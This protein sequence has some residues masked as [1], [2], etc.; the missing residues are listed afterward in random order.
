MATL[1][2][3]S[4]VQRVLGVQMSD[5]DADTLGGSSQAAAKASAVWQ[6]AKEQVDGQLRAFADQLRKTGIPTL[7][8]VADDV[9]T[10]L[11]PL[12]VGLVKALLDYDTAPGEVNKRTAALKRV[13]EA[14]DWIGDDARIREVDANPFG[15]HVT[16]AATLG[17]ALRRLQGALGTKQGA[18][19]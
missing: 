11:Q 16:A 12:R 6:E 1:E 9:G 19:E 3:V 5:G 8:Q 18:A 4:W 7:L 15:V 2:Q 13:T 14:L 17:A 10:F